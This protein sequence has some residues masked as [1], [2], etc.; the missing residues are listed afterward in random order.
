MGD[1]SYET[2]RAFEHELIHHDHFFEDFFEDCVP[3]LSREGVC[4]TLHPRSA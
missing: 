3:G 1:P 2:L 4:M